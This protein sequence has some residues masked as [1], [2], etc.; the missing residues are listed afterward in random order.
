MKKN[1]ID[2]EVGITEYDIFE[3]EHCYEDWHVFEDVKE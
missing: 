2:K 3:N 1:V